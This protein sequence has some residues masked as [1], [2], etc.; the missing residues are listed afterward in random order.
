MKFIGLPL[1]FLSLLSTTAKADTYQDDRTSS[2]TL[3]RS[4]YNA[5]NQ[6]EYAR[7]WSYFADAPAKDFET[8]SKGFDSTD[9]VDVLIGEVS[10]DGAAG[11]TFFNVPVAL[12]AK[13]S[14]GAESFFAGCYVLR[15]VNG[16]VQ[17]PPFRPLSIQSAKLK[18]IKKDDFARYSLPKCGDAQPDVEDTVATV[19]TAKAKFVSETKGACDK[20]QD[21]LA[22]LNEPQVYI[23]KYKPKDAA[24]GEPDNKATLFAFSCAMAA[25]NESNVFYLDGG[26]IGLE[27]LSFTAPKYNY[28]YSDQEN[29]KLK[30]MTFQGFTA[31]SVLTNAE[32]DPATNSISEFAKWR[33]LADAASSGTWVFDDGQFMLKDF[34]ID[35]TYDDEHNPVTVVKNG[36]LIAK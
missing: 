12:R 13:D 17:E 32:F 3:I 22:G 24:V 18:A 14:K 35:P 1:L 5:I 9:H 34:A 19:E 4:L 27:R 36:R 28:A 2:E 10:G 30:S 21:T 20:V 26:A 16:S 23:I 31:S 7:A 8:Y 15:Q 6:H 25:Y 11:S 33:G 29:A